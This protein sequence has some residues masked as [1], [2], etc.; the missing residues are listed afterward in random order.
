MIY[1]EFKILIFP[2]NNSAGTF[3]TVTSGI[4][5]NTKFL[6]NPLYIPFGYSKNF[7]EL[8]NNSCIC[9]IF[10]ITIDNVIINSQIE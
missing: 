8:K 9:P 5:Y 1:K 7:N 2:N 3:D 4:M 6:I 10:N